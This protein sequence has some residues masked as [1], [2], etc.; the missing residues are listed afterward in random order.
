MTGEVP[1]LFLVGASGAGKSAVGFEIFTRLRLDGHMTARVDLDDIGTCAPLR[2]ADP[3]NHRLKARNLG[4]MWPNF[5]AVGAK[6]LVVSG[7]VATRD[8]ADLYISEIPGAAVT[9]CRLRVG[10]QE[11]RRRIMRRAKLLGVGGDAAVSSMTPERVEQL[12]VD[13]RAEA[14][15]LD[16]REI[17]DFC[18]ETDGLDVRSV[19]KQVIAQWDGWPEP[20]VSVRVG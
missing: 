15:D 1:L 18:V 16:R 12:I 11:L 10:A 14:E 5:E 2:D 9:V 17:A 6:F 13:A 8:E 19:A 7:G 4:V 20:A 3:E